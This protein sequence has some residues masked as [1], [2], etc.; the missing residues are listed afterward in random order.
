MGLKRSKREIQ[1]A[2]DQTRHVGG[3]NDDKTTRRNLQCRS[4]EEN[5]HDNDDDD[6]YSVY[7]MTWST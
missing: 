2:L 1:A 6:G 3:L 7:Y 5:I 4:S